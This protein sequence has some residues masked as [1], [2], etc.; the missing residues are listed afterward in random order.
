M[1]AVKTDLMKAIREA[2]DTEVVKEQI[3]AN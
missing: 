2:L 3:A 1:G